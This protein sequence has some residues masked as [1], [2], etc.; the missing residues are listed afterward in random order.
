[1][2][3]LH[4]NTVV[5]DSQSFFAERFFDLF[6]K[7]KD[8]HIEVYLL[9]HGLRTLAN[10]TSVEKLKFVFDV[11]DIDGKCC[12]KSTGTVVSLILDTGL[13][14]IRVIF[15]PFHLQTVSPRLEFAH[16]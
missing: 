13:F 5:F 1:M 4:Q 9:L 3:K 7:E 2:A 15:A 10:G 11:Y 14:S 12:Y 8:G 6:D 16:T